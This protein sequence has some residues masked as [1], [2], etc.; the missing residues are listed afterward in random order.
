MKFRGVE[1]TDEMYNKLK[2]VLYHQY[3]NTPIKRILGVYNDNAKHKQK[4][5]LV[6]IEYISMNNVKGSVL[7]PLSAYRKMMIE[8]TESR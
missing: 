5:N 2:E 4:V 3:G 7:I 6:R 8:I 1:L